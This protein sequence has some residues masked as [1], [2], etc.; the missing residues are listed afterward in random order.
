MSEK[1]AWRKAIEQYE[2]S[3]GEPLEELVKSDEFAEMAAQ[4][5]KGQAQ[6]QRELAASTTQWLHSM[7]LPAASDIAD[8]RTEIEQ[9]REEVRALREAVAPKAK[10]K[11]AAKRKVAPAKPRKSATK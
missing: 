1:P 7:N 9:L 11:P 8:L 5:A 10:P 3:I 2:R 6:I 4:A